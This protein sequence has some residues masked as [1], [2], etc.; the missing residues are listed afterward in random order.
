MASRLIFLPIWKSAHEG[1]M[2]VAGWHRK[3]VHSEQRPA[4][5]KDQA[6]VVVPARALSFISP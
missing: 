2:R 5:L 1:R 4:W 6:H 3:L